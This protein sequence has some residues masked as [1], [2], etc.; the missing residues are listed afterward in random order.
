M[1]PAG[2]PMKHLVWCISVSKNLRAPE[3]GQMSQKSVT[4]W[5]G[6]NKQQGNEAQRPGG[7]WLA[8]AGGAQS[9]PPPAALPSPS[10]GL[11]H[12]RAGPNGIFKL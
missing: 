2:F 4:L 1:S 11:N 5:G 9:A 3:T 8:G 7:H 10:L 6:G 12:C